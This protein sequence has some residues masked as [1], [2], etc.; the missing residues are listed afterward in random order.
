MNPKDICEARTLTM[1][2]FYVAMFAAHNVVFNG[3]PDKPSFVDN[4][5]MMDVYS[6]S[7]RIFRD[8]RE[9]FDRST[10]EAK[11]TEAENKATLYKEMVDNLVNQLASCMSNR[12]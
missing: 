2:Q 9:K 1:H 12:N 3:D 6:T 8:I 11:I 10:M 4:D 5:L 7:I